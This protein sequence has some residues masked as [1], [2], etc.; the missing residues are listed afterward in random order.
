MSD[1]LHKEGYK[2]VYRS[3]S[4]LEFAGVDK[5]YKTHQ[6]DDIKGIL[7]HPRFKIA[8]AWGH[9]LQALIKQNQQSFDFA[10]L[11]VLNIHKGQAI[12]GELRQTP[13]GGPVQRSWGLSAKGS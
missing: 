13:A 4:A 2:L 11:D 8:M 10:L 3:G 9:A 6:F 1:M 5:L 12:H 7:K